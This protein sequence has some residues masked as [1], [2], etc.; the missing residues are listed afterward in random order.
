MIKFFAHHP[1][2]ANLLMVLMLAGGLLSI[3]KLRRETFPDALPTEVQ[4]SVA[5]PGAT[6]EEVDEAIISRLEEELD[7]VQF[8]KEMRSQSL[9]NVGTTTLEMSEGG[10]YNAFRNEIENAVSSINDF[11]D[12][13]EPPVIRRL[14]TRDPVL[15]VL[16]EFD[17]NDSIGAH[18]S[19]KAYGDH[20]KDRLMASPI[21][22]E[23]EVAGF[24]DRVLR[25]EL[26]RAALLAHGPEPE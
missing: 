5:F 24:S 2:A 11:P 1:T 25:V 21:I 12:L 23:V 26:S 4:V 15:D 19:L 20:L 8:L 22:S 13:T 7:S 9:S 6:P 3:G 16:V 14:N 17:S 18:R 10:S